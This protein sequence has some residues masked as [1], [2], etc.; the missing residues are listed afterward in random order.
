MEG[1][2][3]S[4]AGEVTAV[5]RVFGRDIEGWIGPAGVEANQE[6]T[7]SVGDMARVNALMKVELG[8]LKAF[9]PGG[10]AVRVTVLA[11]QVL[12]DLFVFSQGDVNVVPG[13]VSPS[14]VSLAFLQC[15]LFLPS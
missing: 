9:N 5:S 13:V 2:L 1:W 14:S 12:G 3:G 6:S 4:P 8:Y 7:L 10:N 15:L 11:N